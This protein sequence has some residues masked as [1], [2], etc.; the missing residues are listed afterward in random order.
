MNTVP[1]IVSDPRRLH[2]V[3]FGS[4]VN[5][6]VPLPEPDA[7]LVTVIHALLLTAV[8][9]QPAVTVTVLVPFPP[10]AVNDW[11]VGDVEGVHDV[12]DASWLTEKVV[13]AIVSEPVRLP[14]ELLA[15]TV[16]ATMPLPAPDAPLVTV[17]HGLL[18]TAVHG[19][20]VVAVTVLLPFPPA[21]MND[22]LVGEIA[23]EHELAACVTVMVAPAIVS[24]PVR[25][26][27][28]LAATLKVTGPLPVPDAPLVT[29]IQLSLLTA[30]HGQSAAAV[31]LV[32][33]FPPGV[34][35]D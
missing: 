2:V 25:L 27:A 21:A 34:V 12:P 20:P 29:V 11:L 4:T 18:L 33:P 6:T 31:T 3:V 23:G 19:Q 1:A 16:N 28:V 10:D 17:I 7:P 15:A 9:G 26:E 32:L 30:V 8:H 13:P 5:D 24:V 35:N 22:W 14:E